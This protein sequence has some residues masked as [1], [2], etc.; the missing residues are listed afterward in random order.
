MK[1]TLVLVGRPNVGKSTL[2]NRL[3]KTRD[4]LVADMPGLT[5]D[6]HYG[7]GRLGNK[8]FLV[9]DTGGFE[10]Q[11]RTGIVYEMARQAE[12]AIAEADVVLFLVDARA[13]FTPQDQV[14]AD[15]LRRSG[16]PLHLLVNKAE[17]MDR[18]VVA[19]EFHELGLGEPRVIS[20]AHGEGVRELLDLVLAPF[21][22]EVDE[23][24]EVA[25]RGP[26]VAIAGRPNVGKSTLINALLGEDRVIA[27]DMPGTTRDA[28]E[29]PFER[30]GRHYTLIDTAGLR[31]KGRVFEAIEKFSVIKT[32]QAVE[33][34][35]VVVLM[36]DAS[37]D[38]SDQDAHIAGFCIEAGRALVLAVNKWDAIDDYRRERIKQDIAR[39]L[40]FLGFAKVHYISALEGQGIA[41]VL[42]SVDNAYAAAMIKLPTPQLTRVL[43]AAVQKQQPPRR[44][45]VRPKL[46]YA[47]Q[48]GSNPPIIVIHG[49]A[50]DAVPDAYTRYLEKTFLEA[51]NLQGT[52]LRIQ[53]KSSHNPFA[54][55]D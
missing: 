19:A 23:A 10:P 14:I 55:K 12:A 52:P 25:G 46:R 38:I 6:R 4:A 9:V 33:E 50:L 30:N 15:L 54:D 35:N 42:S 31:R 29:V 53:Y 1:P 2:F 11:A 40:N 5:R 41:G 16:R 22:E 44:G 20:G 21:G 43:Q 48:G 47:H 17:G 7:H 49:N 51:F 32:L 28:I 39:K 18:A 24:E 37:Q 36:V 3:T 27:F 45:N 8:P 13:G 34:A 26:R